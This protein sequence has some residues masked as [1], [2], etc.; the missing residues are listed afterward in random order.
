[1]IIILDYTLEERPYLDG[2]LASYGS[3]S[4]NSL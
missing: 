3:G 2:L 1:M 4:R